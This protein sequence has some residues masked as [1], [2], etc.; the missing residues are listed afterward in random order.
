M[1]NKDLRKKIKMNKDKRTKDNRAKMRKN[2][3]NDNLEIFTVLFD[4]CR[5]F[6]KTIFLNFRRVNRKRVKNVIVDT[7]ISLINK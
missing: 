1:I 5:K 3:K 6:H 7:I 4:D 2:P